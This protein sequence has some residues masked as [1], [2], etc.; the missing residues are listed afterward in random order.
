M[1]HGLR[2]HGSL[3]RMLS[4]LVLSGVLAPGQVAFA[5]TWTRVAHNAPGGVNLM[6]LLSDGTVMA[7]NNNGSTIGNAW[8]RLTPDIHGS[9]VNGTWTTLAPAHDSRLYYSSQVLRDGR[10]FVAG[11]E[12]GTGGARAEVYNPLTNVWTQTNPPISLLNPAQNSPVT[13]GPQQFYDSN[14]EILA[15]GNV[16]IAP[17][18]PRVAGQ[19]LIYDPTANLWSAGPHYFRGVYQDEATWVKMP[20]D[21]ILT[22]DPFG[23]NSERYIPA[24]NVWVDDG[25]VPVPIYDPF[26]GEMGGGL[27]LANGNAFFLGATGHTALYTPSGTTSPGVWTAG[28][29]IPSGHGTPDAPAAMMVTGNM[30][31]AVSPA[32]TSGNEFPSP[33]T[34]YEYDPVANSFTSVGAPVGGFDNIPSFAANMVDLPD[35]TVLYSHMGSDVYVY[36]PSGAP[37]ASG[38]PAITSLSQ[39]VDGSYHLIGTGLNGISEGA[40][41][42]DDFQM[43]SNYPLVRLTDGAGNVYYAR[44]YGWSS[45]GVQTGTALV[46][47]EFRLPASLP[48]VPYSLVVVANG[49]SSDPVPL[50]P[51]FTPFCFGGTDVFCPCNNDGG[52]DRGCQNSGGTGGALLSVTGVASL[53]A[54]TVQF[55]SSGEMPSA[56]SIVLQGSV[57]IFPVV[58]GD[59]LRCAGGTLKRLYVRNASGGVIT[60]PHAGDPSVSAQSAALGDPLFFGAA[61]VYQVYYR[62]PNPSFCPS[63]PGGTFN[64]S[65]GIAVTWGS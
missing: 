62:D 16:L 49:I 36:Q 54:D 1:S 30:L 43:N 60:A 3:K 13:G 28:P 55:T 24:S 56:L 19:P 21:S 23:T 33:T 45:T 46:S 12:Y 35:G 64:V 51:F 48:G 52:P 34:F 59:G 44:T 20:D 14:S 7:A 58:Y 6:L 41:Y 57:A 40:T 53:S 61:R 42:G 65:N 2:L 9:Y 15:N 11:G 38:K 29:D 17:V 18:A 27:M 50:A 31:C 25:I 26:G 63:P 5:G 10:V 37:L 4:M 39:N 32:P 22:I 8:F 47:T